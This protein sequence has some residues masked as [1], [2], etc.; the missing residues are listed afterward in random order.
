VNELRCRRVEGEEGAALVEFAVCAVLILTI[1]FG[2]VEFGNA[3]NR[4]LEV[5][6]AAR[7][8]ARVG[9]SLANDRTADQG[10]LQAASSVLNDIGLANVNYVVVFDSTTA[11]G[12]PQGTCASNPPVASVTSKCNV[13]TGTQLQ[14]LG[15][16]NFTS[17]CTG[18]T[19]AAV[20]H[21]WCPTDRN[22]VQSA[23]TD[24]LGVYV[25]VKYVTVTGLFQS[26]FTL[27]SR[28][29]MRVEPK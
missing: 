19:G 2:I 20:D 27:S 12:R 6:T 26:P 18:G 4:K 23:G 9:T 8:G 11:D 15:T 25:Q 14:N 13:Y 3:W 22:H 24:Y 7:A 16:L 21:Y 10:L 29:V 1:V 17:S 28:A 5:E